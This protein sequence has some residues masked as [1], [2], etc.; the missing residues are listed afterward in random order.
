[1]F[2]KGS[3]RKLLSENYPLLGILI[4]IVLVSVSIGPFK[5]GDTQWE[6]QAASGVIKWGMPYVNTFGNI[7]DQP[8]LGFYVEALFFRVFGLSIDTGVV[9]VTLFGLGSTIMVYT[10]GKVLYSKT[11]GLF[12]ALLFGFSPWQFVL[13]RSFLID[14]QCLFLSLLCLFVGVIAIRKDSLKLSTVS[15]IIFAAALLTKLYAVFMLIPL[16]IL[17]VFYQPKNPKRTLSLLGAFFV[18]ALIFAFLWY[19]VIS[20]QGL[21]SIFS[22]GD[23]SNPNYSDVIP[24]YFFVITFLADYGLGWSFIAAAA[25][26]LLVCLFLRKQFS[27][28]LLFDLTCL[29][30]IVAVVSLNTFLGAGLDLKSPYNNAV[31]FDYQIL[32]FFSLLAASLVGKCRS[33]FNSS[34]L[35]SKLRKLPVLL[36]ALAGLVLVGTSILFNMQSAHQLALSDYLLFRVERSVEVGYSLFNPDPIGKN[37]FVMGV[38]YLGFAF[39]LSGLLWASRHKLWDALTPIR[40]WIEK[41]TAGSKEPTELKKKISGA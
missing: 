1:M 32:P 26:S 18:P 5:N 37:G 28:I 40:R 25:V 27:N 31:K 41:K 19:Q 8:P 21:L 16:L 7:M 39:A 35:K 38:Q 14:A 15:G 36:F 29:V 24:S 23:L 6:F 22:H 13:S 2:D 17:Y 9:L 30:I 3:L 10:I 11:T 33:L 4:G 12:A 34:K 20:G